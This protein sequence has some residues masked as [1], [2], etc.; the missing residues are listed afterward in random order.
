MFALILAYTSNVPESKSLKESHLIKIFEINQKKL[1]TDIA[2]FNYSEKILRKWQSYK[3]YLYDG[4]S[5]A[6]SSEAQYCP[7]YRWE[8]LPERDINLGNTKEILSEW[9][10]GENFPKLLVKKLKGEFF[11]TLSTWWNFMSLIGFHDVRP[12]MRRNNLPVFIEKN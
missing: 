3:N 4:S 1:K 5:K 7:V 9:N 8:T 11:D 2:P 6:Y 12:L 10:E